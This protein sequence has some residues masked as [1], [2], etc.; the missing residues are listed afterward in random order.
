MNISNAPSSNLGRSSMM[1]NKRGSQYQ[2]VM[3]QLP[4]IN[5]PQYM[6]GANALSKA[7]SVYSSN[8][9]PMIKDV[10]TSKIRPMSTKNPRRLRK[11]IEGKLSHNA[12]LSQMND[13]D[14]STV[15]NSNNPNNFVQVPFQNFG[16]MD[17]SFT[18]T[19]FIKSPD[20]NSHNLGNLHMDMK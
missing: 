9:V 7:D 18:S 6:M 13:Q 16:G 4:G 2:K 15:W 1:F 10:K 12:D 14:L 5:L 19:N 17:S 11:K 3:N 8:N 20:Y